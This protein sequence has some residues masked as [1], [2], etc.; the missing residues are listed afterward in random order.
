M[1]V[2]DEKKKQSQK[3]KN[4]NTNQEVFDLKRSLVNPYLCKFNL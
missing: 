4:K 2:C 1:T 3:V